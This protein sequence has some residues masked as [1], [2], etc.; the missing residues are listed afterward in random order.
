MKTSTNLSS[1]INGN[2]FVPQLSIDDVIKSIKTVNNKEIKV[3]YSPLQKTTTAYVVEEGKEQLIK[4]EDLPKELK[5]VKDS[6]SLQLLLENSYARASY[7]SNGD[8]KLYMEQRGLGGGKE[9]RTSSYWKKLLSNVKE[10][11]E[12]RSGGEL[13][14][15][16][17]ISYAWEDTSTDAGKANSKLQRWLEGLRDDLQGVGVS[18]FL[19]IGD[20]HGD[21]GKRMRENLDASDII[22][23][24]NTPRYAQRATQVPQTNLGFE[25]ELTLK[26]AEVNPKSVVTLHFDGELDKAYPESLKH[27]PRYDCRKLEDYSENLV[28]MK[29]LPGII[30]TILGINVNEDAGYQSLVKQWREEKLNYLPEVNKEFVGRIEQLEKLEKAL[31]DKPVQAISGKEGIGKS[32]LALKYAND[33]AEQYKIVRW[34]NAEPGNLKKEFKQIAQ[35]LAINTKGLKG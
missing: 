16:A 31:E 4:P 3:V 17:F 26:K 6:A 15:K 33:H 34:I 35:E 10:L 19:D 23:T 30:P 32:E 8:V 24:I 27:F 7:L 28:G 2:L 29:G 12:E 21:M 14:L 18:V 11:V 1:N 5:A 9:D 22:L 13:G 25:Y 20:M